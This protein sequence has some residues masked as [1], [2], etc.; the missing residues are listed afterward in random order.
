[1]FIVYYHNVVE[2]DLDALDRRA[3]R[4]SAAGFR[5]QVEFLAEHYRP[6]GL[7][8]MLE[9]LE[10]GD[11]D[12]RCVTVTFD[13][14]Y[15][16]VRR[17]AAP[18]MADCGVP[19]AVFAVTSCLE[20]PGTLLHFEEMEVA[21]RLTSAVSLEMP[22]LGLPAVRLVS[23]GARAVFLKRVKTALKGVADG[24]R[25]RLQDLALERLGVTRQAMVAYAAEEPRL[26]KMTAEDLRALGFEVGGHTRTHRVLS[27]LPVEEAR[28]EIAGCYE[29]L[30]GFAPRFFA[31]PYGKPEHV[32]EGVPEMVREAGFRAALSTRNGPNGADFD[33]WMLRRVEFIDLLAHADRAVQEAA[34]RVFAP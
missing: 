14:A 5:R 4:A 18:I 8:E 2:G 25:R 19:G 23:D 34:R 28:S 11:L 20:H 15:A 32:G 6:V 17:V 7:A 31:Y 22:E 21:L 29:D 33:R 24:E 30:A 16:G 9:R 26:R 1:M 3:S 27:R 10:A 13:D 12:P